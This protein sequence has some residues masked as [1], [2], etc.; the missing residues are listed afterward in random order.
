MIGEK[1]DLCSTS[2]ISRA[3]TKFVFSSAKA[4]V[5][6]TDLR[7]V[8]IRHDP[9]LLELRDEFCYLFVIVSAVVIGIE[10]LALL[11]VRRVEICEGLS[12]Q[13]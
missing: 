13:R 11:V 4:F 7:A 2:T 12:W 5:H 3:V 1:H 8:V 9:R 10:M 6:R